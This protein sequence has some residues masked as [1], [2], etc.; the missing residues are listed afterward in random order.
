VSGVDRI[1]IPYK[2]RR[3]LIP[4]HERT[5]RWAVFVAHRRLGKTVGCV[6]DLIKRAVECPLPHPRLG[7]LAPYRAQA[8]E[9]AWEYLKRYSQPIRTD[10][11]ESEL[12]VELVTGARIKVA[13]ADNP[14][15]LRGAYLDGVVLDEAAQMRPTVWGEVI[16][17]M[18]ADRKG[19]ATFIG[20]PKGR[21]SFYRQLVHAQKHPDEWFSAIMRQS[22]TGILDA[23]EVAEMVRDMDENEIAQ[24]L[25][26]S[27]DAA[28]KGAYY[29]KQ[30]AHAE[31]MGRMD[32]T[33]E[34]DTDFPVDTAWDL[35]KTDPTGIWMFQVAP[36]GIR[37]LDYYENTSED[38]DH[39]DAKLRELFELRGW[40]RGTDWLPH[41][42]KAKLIGMKR[43][44]VEQLQAMGRTI[45]VVP[46]HEVMDGINAVRMSF[47]RF[48]F[49]SVRCEEGIEMLRQ[50][51]AKYDEKRDIVGEPDHD[52]TSHCA[53]AFRYLAMAW[54]ELQV[55]GPPQGPKTEKHVFWV[56]EGGKL[57]TNKSVMEII[58]EAEKR[59]GRR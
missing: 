33:L 46:L 3:V 43:T 42:A 44:R 1:V 16:R 58:R 57:R 9:A 49:N 17:P 8:K 6:N 21:N 56:G 59:R 32:P 12:W 20:T 36:N 7:Y 22:Q 28:I 39:Y 23:D 27:F 26:C 2:P 38:L 47:S 15:S 4:Y 14:D 24:E 31:G 25:E 34:A 29:A 5:Q 52:W 55:Q 41:D 45:R 19:W 30:I 40:Q 13:G 10:L 37:L 48:H 54:R 11:N 53:D 50:Y 18:L 35:G 51:H